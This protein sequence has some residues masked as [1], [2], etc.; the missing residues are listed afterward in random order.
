V[1]DLQPDRDAVERLRREVALGGRVLA[2]NGHADYIWGHVGARDPDNR[3][4]WIKAS[5]PTMEEVTPDDVILVDRSGTVLEGDGAVHNEYPLHTEILAARPDIGA[6]VHTHPVAAVALSATSRELLPISNS[7]RTFVPPTVPRFVRTAELIR[8]A[9]L[10]VELAEALGEHDAIF[11]VHHGIVVT[12]PDVARAVA[13]AAILERAC[14]IQLAA[15]EITGSLEPGAAAR[16]ANRARQAERQLEVWAHLVR[17]L[18][19][20]PW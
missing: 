8:T 15:G 17:R 19:P 10:G 1:A 14:R 2:A 7:A 13:R 16:P 12:G 3:G 6:V 18:G 5:A 20:L 11:L 9:E 4:V